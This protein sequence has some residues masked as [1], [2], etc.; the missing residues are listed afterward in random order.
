MEN[1]PGDE[2]VTDASP[3]ALDA[4]K[5]VAANGLGGLDL[6][7]HLAEHGIDKDVR[8]LVDLTL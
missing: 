7:R 5:V 2:L 4:A 3:E 6:D 1:D 8:G